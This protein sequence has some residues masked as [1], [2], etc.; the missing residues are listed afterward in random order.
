MRKLSLKREYVVDIADSK[1]INEGPGRWDHKRYRSSDVCN[2]VYERLRNSNVCSDCNSKTGFINGGSDIICG[3]CGLVVDNVLGP[4]YPDAPRIAP[5]YNGYHSKNYVAEWLYQLCARCTPIPEEH[6][7]QM[8]P[9]FERIPKQYLRRCSRNGAAKL[10]QILF[11]EFVE[12]KYHERMVW[13]LKRMNCLPDDYYEYSEK[14]ITSIYKQ[15][16]ILYKTWKNNPNL[17]KGKNMIHIKYELLQLIRLNKC[18]FNTFWL[19]HLNS[20]W[21]KEK[22]KEYNK[23]WESLLSYIRD[24]NIEYKEFYDWTYMELR[25]EDLYCSMWHYDEYLI[26]WVE[27]RRSL[28]LSFEPENV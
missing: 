15:Y 10:I 14:V 20:V 2:I 24:S 11:P 16:E 17:Q 13:L 18:R 7:Q 3:N 22:L 26:R 19:F 27:Q 9:V 12:K 5:N 25:L 4:G 8:L 6:L 28:L 23:Q 1:R 21:S